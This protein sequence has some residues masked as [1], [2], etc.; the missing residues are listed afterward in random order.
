M[1][2]G[3]AGTSRDLLFPIR[4][5]F[6]HSGAN[7]PTA[8]VALG[9]AVFA[10]PLQHLAGPVPAA[11]GTSRPHLMSSAYSA[12]APRAR[13]RRPTPRPT[14]APLHTWRNESRDMRRPKRGTERFDGMRV[15]SSSTA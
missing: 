11:L 1:P 2:T 6:T 15:L 7:V 3:G 9:A 13:R 5:E 4:V 10:I 8:S 12:I 14:K